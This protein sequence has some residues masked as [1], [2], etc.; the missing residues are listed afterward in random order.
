MQL[1]SNAATLVAV[2]AD[3]ELRTFLFGLDSGFE[4]AVGSKT[5]LV[6]R[7][8]LNFFLFRLSA[9]KAPNPLKEN[10]MG[11]LMNAII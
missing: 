11:I 5:G 7:L 10:L 2:D 9:A 8:L 6:F 1:N 4:G 3:C